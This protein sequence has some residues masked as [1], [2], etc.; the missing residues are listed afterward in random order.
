MAWQ[1]CL[2]ERGA[3][4]EMLKKKKAKTPGKQEKKGDDSCMAFMWTLV[5]GSFTIELHLPEMSPQGKD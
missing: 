5:L 4:R 3:A 2:Y 1:R